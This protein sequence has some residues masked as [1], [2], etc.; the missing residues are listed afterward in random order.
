MA[1]LS[2][3]VKWWLSSA[4]ATG[5]FYRKMPNHNLNSLQTSYQKSKMDEF[6]ARI[7]YRKAFLRVK[8]LIL[9]PKS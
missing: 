7:A 9:P 4:F 8:T 2:F 1:Y 6:V 5:N 3:A